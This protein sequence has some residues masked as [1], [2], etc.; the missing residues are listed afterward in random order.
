[1]SLAVFMGALDP[2]E[3]DTV[4]LPWT[5]ITGNCKFSGSYSS[6]AMCYSVTDISDQ[7]NSTDVYKGQLTSGLSLISPEGG[8]AAWFTTAQ[9]FELD[10]SAETPL[11]EFQGLGNAIGSQIDLAFQA[12]WY[13][14]I[15]TY[16]NVSISNFELHQTTV[17][18]RPLARVNTADAY[19]AMVGELSTLPGVDCSPSNSPQGS[20]TVPA[21][22]L[23]D[24]TTN[25]FPFY[26]VD[27]TT[28]IINASSNAVWYDPSC[29]WLFGPG[30]AI[31]LPNCL[32]LMFGDPNKPQIVTGGYGASGGTELWMVN[33]AVVNTSSEISEATLDTVTGYVDQIARSLTIAMRQNGDDTN[34][35]PF[36][37][38]MLVEKTCV[39]F[40]GLYLI[41]DFVLWVAGVLVLFG[42]LSKSRGLCWSRRKEKPGAIERGA[43]KSSI[44]P[45]V[46]LGVEDADGSKRETSY[47]TKEEMKAQSELLKVRLAKES[48]P[49][50]YNHLQTP[51]NRDSLQ[52]NDSIDLEEMPGQ[53]E[54]RLILR[55]EEEAMPVKRRKWASRL[56]N[57]DII[58]YALPL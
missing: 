34:S 32:Q 30:P 26:G 20:K 17:S 50:K 7:L 41:Y 9:T 29:T 48:G 22:Q 10:P 36:K 21:R 15:K 31:S 56:R 57:K 44:L 8:L 12:S 16:D 4:G 47:N 19:F 52:E 28:E 45:L 42:V 2:P 53:H 5:C 3:N 11:F 43:W 6:L 55:V 49:W 39:R 37:G 51:E 25:L 27:A 40:A 58:D 35:I 46:W 18:S 33:L 23:S 38:Q 24:G 14:C 13:P 1:M 54:E